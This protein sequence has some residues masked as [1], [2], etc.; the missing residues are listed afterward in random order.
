MNRDRPPAQARTARPDFSEAG[1]EALGVLDPPDSVEELF[2]SATIEPTPRR[3]PGGG[4]GRRD[5]ESG[6]SGEGGG[7]G[8]GETVRVAILSLLFNWPSTGGGTVHTFELARELGTAGYE[9]RHIFA[10]FAP[11]EIGRVVGPLPYDAEPLDFDPEDWHEDAIRDRFR[12]ALD[13]FDPDRVILTDSWNSK[14]LLAEAARAYPTILRFQ[15]SECLCPLNNVRLL[16]GDAPGRLAQCGNH[17]LARPEVC[18]ACVA[19]LGHCSGGLHRAERALVGFGAPEYPARVE[20]M[21]AGAMATLVVNPL[22]EAM[23]SPYTAL[24]RVVTSGMDPAR[25]PEPSPP[26]SR[27]GGPLRLLFAGLVDEVMKGF[28]VLH[29]A[30]ALLWE[31]RQD[32]ELLVTG[33]GGLDAPSSPFLRYVGWQSQADLPARAAEADIVVVPTVAQE[34]LGRTAVEGMAAGRP[35]VASRLGGLPFTILDGA[36][37]LLV[38]PGDPHDLARALGELMDDADLCDRLGAA[39]RRRFLEHYAWPAIIARGYAPLLGR[40]ERASGPD[41]GGYTPSYPPPAP[42]AELAEAI[43]TFFGIDPAR[44]AGMHAAYRAFH[45]DRGYE[46]SLGEFKTLCLDEAFL[47][48]LVLSIDRP[49]AILVLE[50]EGGRSLRRIIDLRDFLGLGCLILTAGG[51]SHRPLVAPH[52]FDPLPG[53]LPPGQLAETVAAN[54]IGLVYLDRHEPDLLRE[55][56]ALALDADSNVVVA[57]HDCGPGQCNAAMRIDRD[58]AEVT[59]ATGVWQRHLLAESLGVDDPTGSDLDELATATHRVRIFPTT[60]GLAL[61]ARHRPVPVSS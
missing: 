57:L 8:G 7:G 51:D 37:G 40:R 25:F 53:G 28:A 32:F 22:M 56:I 60:H 27:A 23:V 9:V 31:R 49:S 10:R 54:G 47:L 43:G 26:P 39:G 35:V 4:H 44:V 19:A 15:A 24:T 34:A 50:G 21:F 29:E 36:T 1:G 30:C 59:S 14:P 41:L 46:R 38:E 58:A 20:A 45:R 3:R 17:Q 55:T 16:P 6:E 2:P 18:V 12:T 42:L 13:E 5:G 11:W 52:E 48:C 33:E 61:V